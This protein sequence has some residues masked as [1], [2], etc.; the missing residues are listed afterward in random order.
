MLT[1][2]WETRVLTPCW[3]TGRLLQPLQ[4]TGGLPPL[5]CDRQFHSLVCALLKHPL[6]F[7]RRLF[8]AARPRIPYV[9]DNSN[10]H[11][12]LVAVCPS[13]GILHRIE[14][15]NCTQSDTNVC[16][17]HVYSWATAAIH[18]E[19][20]V[21]GLPSGGAGGGWSLRG[22]PLPFH[23]GAGPASLQL[24]SGDTSRLLPSLDRQLL[25]M[26]TL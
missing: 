6:K 3:W 2:T 5:R 15:D 10:V 25:G 17:S 13:D 16:T 7:T 12:G 23:A 11:G 21:R 14:R 8:I 26:G 19:Q 9:G 18:E 20:D 1:R 24:D 4:E 22:C